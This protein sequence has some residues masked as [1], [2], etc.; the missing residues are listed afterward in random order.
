MDVQHLLT[1]VETFHRADHYT[2]RVLAAKT[3]LGD[4]MRHFT[5]LTSVGFIDS[6]LI[7]VLGCP[8]NAASKVCQANVAH[9]TRTGNCCTPARTRILLMIKNDILIQLSEFVV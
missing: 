1:L 2:V 4:Y 9:F 3:W 7:G 8:C 6:V 5:F